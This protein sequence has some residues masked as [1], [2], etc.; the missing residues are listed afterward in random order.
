M[1]EFYEHLIWP[2]KGIREAQTT[3]LRWEMMITYKP[4]V[5]CVI[6]DASRALSHSWIRGRR[7]KETD[8][9]ESTECVL[10]DVRVPRGVFLK[11]SQAAER[12]FCSQLHCMLPVTG[13]KL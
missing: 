2:G 6:E 1:I 9:K 13:A 4:G 3:S 8:S 7:C 11:I 5:V 10:Q 12:S